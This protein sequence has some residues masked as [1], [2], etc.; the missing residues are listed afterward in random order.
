MVQNSV[1]ANSATWRISRRRIGCG[2]LCWLILSTLL[3]SMVDERVDGC[4]LKDTNCERVEQEKNPQDDAGLLSFAFFWLMK[5]KFCFF[6][7]FFSGG[8]TLC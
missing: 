5:T 7:M 2:L 8:C 3:V 1:Q 4:K 6:E